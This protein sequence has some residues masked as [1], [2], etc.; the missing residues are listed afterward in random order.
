M[1]YSNTKKNR[2]FA[3]VKRPRSL[4]DK[5]KDS[6]SLAVGSIPAEGTEKGTKARKH[7]SAK[8]C[9]I[10]PQKRRSL[11]RLFC[12]VIVTHPPYSPPLTPPMAACAAAKRAIG[13]RKG[14]HET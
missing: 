4:M 11:D 5:M 12:G 7:E 10:T 8:S 14:E 1:R 6:G 3:A 9:T 2:T 13:T